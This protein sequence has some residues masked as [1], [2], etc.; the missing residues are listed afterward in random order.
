[1][2]AARPLVAAMVEG[3]TGSRVVS[4]HHDI[5]TVT[6]EEVVLFT[7]AEAPAVRESS[8]GPGSARARGLRGVP[9]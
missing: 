1:M 7:L 6:G 9:A 8:S 2:E 4:M 5:S 3:V